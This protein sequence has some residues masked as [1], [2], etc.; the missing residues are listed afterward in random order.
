MDI[1]LRLTCEECSKLF[2]VDDADVDGDSLFCPFCQAGVQV[3][4]SEED[5]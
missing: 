3:P 1:L 4:D 5:Y 2:I